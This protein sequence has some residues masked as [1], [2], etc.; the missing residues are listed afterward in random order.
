MIEI[1]PLSETRISEVVEFILEQLEVTL[2]DL[3]T[4]ER[5]AVRQSILP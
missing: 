1:V 3:A 5:Q 4:L 2:S